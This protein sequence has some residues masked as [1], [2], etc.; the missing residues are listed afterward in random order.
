MTL[1][2]ASR[3]YTEPVGLLESIN[4]GPDWTG[5]ACRE[6]DPEVWFP[7][8][9]DYMTGAAAKAICETCPVRERC[10]EAAMEWESGSHW[11]RYGLW[12]GLDPWERDELARER[13]RA[14]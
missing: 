7:G 3:R 2:P 10:L 14:G 5:A 6:H 11:Q 9:G 4:A 12:G 1:H 8:Q 13:R